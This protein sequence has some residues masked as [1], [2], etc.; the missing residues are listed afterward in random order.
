MGSAVGCQGEEH[1]ISTTDEGHGG[2]GRESTGAALNAPDGSMNGLP[3][4]GHLEGSRDR[5]AAFGLTRF[6]W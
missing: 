2:G 4:I 1:E 5:A 6:N 3:V